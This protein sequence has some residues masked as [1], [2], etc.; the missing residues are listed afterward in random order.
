MAEMTSK[1]CFACGEIVGGVFY[2]GYPGGSGLTSGAVFGRRAGQGA[3]AIIER[4]IEGTERSLSQYARGESPGLYQACGCDL[5]RCCNRSGTSGPQRR[6]TGRW[7]NPWAWRQMCPKQLMCAFMHEW[8]TKALD[9][10]ANAI[11]SLPPKRSAR[12]SRQ[13]T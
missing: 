7:A 3:A 2:A 10:L 6:L 12:I 11:A 5:P 1:D 4:G 9:I 13:G 8:R